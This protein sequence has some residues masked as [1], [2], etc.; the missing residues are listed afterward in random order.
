[1]VFIMIFSYMYIIY[2]DHIHI[3][4]CLPSLLKLLF[5]LVIY[6]CG[7]GLCVCMCVWWGLGSWS[8]ATAYI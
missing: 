3:S 4:S 2:F 5:L 7:G 1:M 8:C 6:V